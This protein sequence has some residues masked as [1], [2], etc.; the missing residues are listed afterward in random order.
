MVMHRISPK[1]N[2]A[3]GDRVSSFWGTTSTQRCSMHLSS[4]PLQHTLT[5]LGNPPDPALMFTDNKCVDGVANDTVTQRHSKAMD[6][7]YHF[8]RD[9][10]RQGQIR[11]T[12]N[13]ADYLTKT[14]PNKHFAAMRPFSVGTLTPDS[15]WTTVCLTR[16]VPNQSRLT[17]ADLPDPRVIKCLSE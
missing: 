11:R 14:H 6:M 17:T 3:L 4:A 7:R 13:L 2:L 9:R 16:G 5:D 8:V 12:T 15:S 1:P 10:V